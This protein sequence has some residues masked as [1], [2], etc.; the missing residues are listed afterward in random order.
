MRRSLV[1]VAL[2]GTAFVACAAEPQQLLSAAPVAPIPG[3]TGWVAPLGSHVLP[4]DWE[5]AENGF[6][7]WPTPA[8]CLA[9]SLWTDF[10]SAAGW[11]QPGNVPANTYR[12]D[13]L[14]PVAAQ[15]Q[16]TYA[17]TNTYVWRPSVA[18][19]GTIYVCTAVLSGG[20]NGK[21]VALQPDGTVKWTAQLTTPGGAG[22]WCSA[23]PVLD[24]AGNIYIAWAHDIDFHSLTALAYD[25]NGTCLWRYQPQIELEYAQHMQGVV[26]GGVFYVSVDTS[27]TGGDP[28]HRGSVIAIDA[29]GGTPR[30]RWISANLDTYFDGPSVGSDGAVYVATAANPMRGANGWLYRLLPGGTLDWSYDLGGFGVNCA[31][32]L[33]ANNDVYLGDLDGVAWKITTA[34]T[35]GW[36]YNTQSGRIYTTPALTDGKV[37]IGAA[38]AGLHIVDAATGTHLNTL[39][40]NNYP[41][42]KATDGLGNIYFYCYDG[43]GTVLAFSPAGN[44]RCQFTTGAGVSVNACIVGADGRVLVGNSQVLKSVTGPTQGDTNCDGNVDFLDINPFVLA[45]TDPQQYQ[46]QYPNCTLATADINGDGAVNFDDINPFVA[47]LAG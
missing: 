45:L 6:A 7:G 33:D 29:A 24:D 44:Q 15:A 22:V 19:D 13:L 14:G 16:W 43:P 36:T 21:L 20:V 4:R 10:P 46:V 31:P 25:P 32:A 17:P 18:P 47:L 35:F 37:L 2:L 1:I 38:N 26:T 39:A 40:A 3:E 23:T 34:G 8:D 9:A 28:Q 41:M 42:N 12:T 27:W 5:A 11:P 30:W